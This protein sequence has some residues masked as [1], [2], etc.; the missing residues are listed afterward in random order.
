MGCG[1]V[2]AGHEWE[3]GVVLNMK[4][5]GEGKSA[6]ERCVEAA[7]EEPLRREL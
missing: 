6:A 4:I 5:V 3:L 7:G 1:G 2:K